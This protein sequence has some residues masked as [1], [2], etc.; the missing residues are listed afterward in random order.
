MASLATIRTS[1]PATRPIPV[2]MPADGASLSYRSHA[3]SADSSRNGEPSSSSFAIR[4]RTGSFPC[5]RCRSRYFSPPPCLTSAVRPASSATRAVILSRLERNRSE[6]GSMWDS[7]M[8]II[9]RFAVRGSRFAIPACRGSRFDY[10]PQQSVLYRQLGQRHT[11]C[12]RNISAPQRS[13]ITISSSAFFRGFGE[14]AG[15][16]AV[17]FGSGMHVIIRAQPTPPCAAAGVS[18]SDSQEATYSVYKPDMCRHMD[19]TVEMCIL[20]CA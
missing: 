8:S 4:S 1:R 6:A 10:Q 19:A 18:L 3:A 14:E 7:R 11:A 5:P 17:W 16:W 12:I 20:I 2:T 9:S 13:Q 15:G